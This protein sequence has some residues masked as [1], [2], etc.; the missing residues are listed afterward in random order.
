VPPFL[1]NRCVTES[2]ATS[3]KAMNIGTM[4]SN[5]RMTVLASAARFGL[6]MRRWT[7]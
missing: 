5:V 7:A 3:E 2:L 1:H 4:K 6:A